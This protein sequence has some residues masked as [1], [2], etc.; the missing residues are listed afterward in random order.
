MERDDCRTEE[1]AKLAELIK[2]V[3][4]AMFTTVDES[5]ELRSRPMGIQ[6][7]EFD[8]DLWFFTREHSPKMEEVQKVREVNVSWEDKGKQ[9]YVSVSGQAQIVDDRA[10]M[11]EL[12][13]PVLKVWFPDG[14]K[15]PEISL[16]KVKVSKAEY[17][18]GPGSK[19]VQFYGFAKA[20]LTGKEFEGGE[21]G[22]IEL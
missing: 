9:R 21:H 3:D 13:S 18:D 20:L 11:E 22:K 5:G 7:V 10:K 16:L 8:G 15:D 12:W 14:L 2:D 17:W 1:I 6:E 19:V 4:I